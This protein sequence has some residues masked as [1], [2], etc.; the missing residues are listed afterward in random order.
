MGVS[1][2]TRI[3]P[4]KAASLDK[5]EERDRALVKGRSWIVDK[6]IFFEAIAQNEPFMFETLQLHE[7]G[8]VS[9]FWHEYEIMALSGEL[10]GITELP[11]PEC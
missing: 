7:N 1:E 5:M 10:V 11:K 8:V 2:V 3:A 9:R 6:A 4:G